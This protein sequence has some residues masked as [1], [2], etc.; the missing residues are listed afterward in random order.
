MTEVIEKAQTHRG[1]AALT[2]VAGV[3][4]ALMGSSLPGTAM[5]GGV[6]ADAKA[7]AKAARAARS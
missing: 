1:R 2:Q 5:S 6:W 7:A 3:G 4:L